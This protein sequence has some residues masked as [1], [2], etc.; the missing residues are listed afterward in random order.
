MRPV[1]NFF[2][3]K[4]EPGWLSVAMRE[5][6]IDLVHVRRESG[7]KPQVLLAD[8]VENHA[9]RTA[10]LTALRKSMRLDRYR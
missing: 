4:I 5:G 9:D 10:A 8:S 2:K 7:R 6:R 3:P 1:P